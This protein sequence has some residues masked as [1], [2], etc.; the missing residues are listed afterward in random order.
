MEDSILQSL[1]N[2]LLRQ[3][4]LAQISKKPL[5]PTQYIF[6]MNL[7]TVPTSPLSNGLKSKTS[8]SIVSKP[9]VFG[10]RRPQ[11]LQ[12][13][14]QYSSDPKMCSAQVPN[15]AA[16]C[17]T[18]TALDF[19]IRKI[20]TKPIGGQKTESSGLRKK[21]SVLLAEYAFLPNWIQS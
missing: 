20:R 5:S 16:S 9:L 3:P 8:L 10:N 17:D 11:K 7:T 2:E 4:C 14:T 15:T 1:S 6:M 12:N 19:A 13:S 18:Q 21:T